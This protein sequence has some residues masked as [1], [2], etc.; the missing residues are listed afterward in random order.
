MTVQGTDFGGASKVLIDAQEVTTAFVDSTRLIGHVPA[1]VLAVGGPHQVQVR[2]DGGNRSNVLTLTILIPPP[3]LTSILPRTVVVGS[4]SVTLVASGDN[5][6]SGAVLLIDGTSVTTTFINSH[7]LRSTVP[8]SFF[9][10]PGTKQVGVRNPD[11][12]LSSTA[13]L[14]VILPTT[15]VTSIL[16]VTVTVG[17]PGFSLSV[18][19]S[20]F[21]SGAVVFFDQTPLVNHFTSATQLLADVP[22]LL[23]SALGIHAVSV[24]NLGESPSNQVI[25]EVLPDPPLIGS[26]DPPSVI[27][28]AGDITVTITGLKFQPGAV[29]LVIE[30][31]QGEILDTT[32]INSQQLQAR[33]P[34]ALT[35]TPSNVQIA[36]VNPDSGT[37]NVVTLKV[38]IKDPLVVNEYLADPP[39]GLEGDAN[40][41]GTRS[42]SQDEFV[43]ILNRS[44][45]PIDIS[46]YK[47]S[48]ADDVRHVFAPGTIIPAFEAAVVFGGG[49]PSG[50]FGN[51]AE[52]HLVF[53]ASTGGLSLNN[54]GDSIILQDVQGHVVQKIIFGPKE[55]GAS[56]SLNLYASHDCSRRL[57][58]LVLARV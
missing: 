48:D 29:V 38:F 41:D 26:I 58:P 40:G 37:S 3:T 1:S 14:E 32:V 22:A 23:V 42:S 55:G 44:A 2:N 31:L 56:Q 39:A 5:F 53:K 30:G 52:N 57:Q 10:V 16:P 35:Q 17:S 45:D 13:S 8:A 27:A 19:G 47:L 51:A 15:V 7:S 25:F 20:N 9:T 6:I 33:V 34:A 18:K 21:K 24:Q 36:V 50:S 49:T 28:G 4:G 46:G 12:K 54:G 11:G 43:E